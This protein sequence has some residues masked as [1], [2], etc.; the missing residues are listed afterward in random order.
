MPRNAH[1]SRNLR[2]GRSRS[3]SRQRTSRG[4]QVRLPLRSLR[5][6]TMPPR[7]RCQRRW[8]LQYRR[9][10]RPRRSCPIRPSSRPQ[11]RHRRRCGNSL[12]DRW[13]RF[14]E[15]PCSRSRSS[16]SRGNHHRLVLP[17]RSN[18]RRSMN[19]TSRPNRCRHPPQRTRRWHLSHHRP[20]VR[21]SSPVQCPSQR[22]DRPCKGR[23]IALL[24]RQHRLRLGQSRHPMRQRP[25]PRKRP[26]LRRRTRNRHRPTRYPRRTHPQ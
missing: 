26:R 1:A 13:P 19:G 4:R 21:P 22:R 12:V 2:K 7:R 24:P 23:P 16:P 6:R 8:F 15:W 14:R 10:R 9:C 11:R 5:Q 25:Q 20:R 3:D 17:R 18:L